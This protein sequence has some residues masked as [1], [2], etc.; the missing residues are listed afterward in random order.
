MARGTKLGAL[1]LWLA[2]G[3]CGSSTP[4]SQQDVSTGTGQDIPMAEA[5]PGTPHPDSNTDDAPLNFPTPAPVDAGAPPQEGG[6]PPAGEGGTADGGRVSALEAPPS[7]PPPTCIPSQHASLPVQAQACA[8]SSVWPDG[9]RQMARYDADGRLLELDTKDSAGAPISVETHTWQDGLE[10]RSRITYAD[11]RFDQ[12]D[13]TYDAQRRMIKRVTQGSRPSTSEFIYDELGRLEKEITDGFITEYVYDALGRLVSIDDSAC[14]EWP[15][16]RTCSDFTYWDNGQLKSRRQLKGSNLVTLDDY[17]ALGQL[18][19]SNFN[20][21]PADFMTDTWWT[22]DT[23]GRVSRIQMRTNRYLGDQ[24]R[25]TTT[26][27]EPDGWRERFAEDTH[28]YSWCD[29]RPCDLVRYTYR[30]IT[31]RASVICGTS[32]LA[33]DEWDSNEDGLV[34]ARRTHERDRAGRLVKEQYS[35]TPGMDEGPVS[36]RFDYACP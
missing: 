31:H 18:I 13:W 17:N 11:G 4:A 15:Y 25:L 22:F 3:G 30:R 23:A 12:T 10:L 27:H 6:G 8:I 19:H 34:D 36:R 5:N 2:C 28:G 9:R 1:F 20:A 33:L 14:G 21:G 24:A 16:T 7:L 32:I 26:F 29:D 35:G